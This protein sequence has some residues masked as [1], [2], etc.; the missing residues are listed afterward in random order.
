MGVDL[1]G[2]CG[3]RKCGHWSISLPITHGF[4]FFDVASTLWLCCLVAYCAPPQ[5]LLRNEY[6]LNDDSTL[7]I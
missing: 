5:A 1:K 7:Y 2:R 3:T 6:D 4:T